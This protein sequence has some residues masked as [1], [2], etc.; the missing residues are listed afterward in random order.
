MPQ[1]IITDFGAEFENID[2][3]IQYS[4]PK[5]TNHISPVEY[6]QCTVLKFTF[7]IKL[8]LHLENNNRFRKKKITSLSDYTFQV[9]K[10]FRIFF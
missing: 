4:A 3:K 10:Q 8:E 5:I 9:K 1:K 2:L 6:F 7:C